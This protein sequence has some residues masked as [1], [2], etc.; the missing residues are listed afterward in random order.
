MR[1]RERET[2]TEKKGVR[3]REKGRQTQRGREIKIDQISARRKRWIVE[4]FPRSLVSM[5][6]LVYKMGP[7]SII[8]SSKPTT[9]HLTHT[10]I[11][12]ARKLGALNSAVTHHLHTADH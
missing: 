12:T 10:H 2:G 1:K 5:N 3:K 9:H 8:T 4:C 11:D 6:V 7:D